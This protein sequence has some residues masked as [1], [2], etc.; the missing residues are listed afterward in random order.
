M[1]TTE[2]EVEK[3]N[4]YLKIGAALKLESILIKKNHDVNLNAMYVL[5]HIVISKN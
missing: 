2:K 5:N 3:S 1:V 4:E